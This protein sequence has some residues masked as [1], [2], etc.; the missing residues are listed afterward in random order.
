M[1]GTA[2]RTLRVSQWATIA[3]ATRWGGTTAYRQQ[4]VT[5]CLDTAAVLRAYREPLEGE[6]WLIPSGSERR[7]LAQ[8]NVIIALGPQALAQVAAL[9]L[10][11]GAVWSEGCLPPR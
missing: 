9:S 3:N 7:L 1:S 5:E 10:D 11:H 2:K 8:A 4:A 6:T